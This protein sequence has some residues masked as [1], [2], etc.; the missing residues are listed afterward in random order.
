M[1][2]VLPGVSACPICGRVVTIDDEL[3]GTSGIYPVPSHLFG[4]CDV[5]MHWDCYGAWPHREEFAKAL[6]EVEVES[7]RSTGARSVTIKSK[8]MSNDC[9]TTCV[10]TS[11]RPARS[12]ES[13][14]WNC[15][16]EFS[17]SERAT[18]R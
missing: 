12:V 17:P 4:Y 3:F 1:A 18:G 10:A 11:T 9:S 13:A 16:T 5:A 7:I 8:S 14:H 15:D 6:F 2:I